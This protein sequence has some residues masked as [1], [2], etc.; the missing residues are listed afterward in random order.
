MEQTDV[1]LNDQLGLAR[2][3]D[4]IHFKTHKGG[5]LNFSNE[6]FLSTVIPFL[7]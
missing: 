4:K 7:Q 6:W 3:S 1:Y 2:M 5:H